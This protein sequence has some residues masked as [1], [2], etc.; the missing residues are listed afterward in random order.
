[1]PAL[2]LF[3]LFACLAAGLP[4][5][6]LSAQSENELRELEPVLVEA[7]RTEIPIQEAPAAI[8][9]VGQEA[10]QRGKQQIAIDEALKNVPGVFILNRYNFAQDTRISV[11]GFGA[12]ADFGIRG[13]KLMVDGIPA[14]TADGQGG[15]DGIDF[16]SSESIEVLRGPAAALYGTASGG[17]IRMESESGPSEPFAE[18]RYA[19]GEHGFQNVQTKAGGEMDQLNYMVS[20]SR[21]DFAGYRNHSRTESLKFNGKF[22]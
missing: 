13:I 5:L 21:L 11:R 3:M 12:Q 18:T 19:A 9:S 2:F 15:V 4:T 7:T 6:S 17:V 16:G 8:G 14:T 1:M 10:I 20:A 22:T